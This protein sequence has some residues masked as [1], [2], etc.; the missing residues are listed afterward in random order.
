MERSIA[1]SIG[2]EGMSVGTEVGG[3]SLGE[4]ARSTGRG[5]SM[6]ESAPGAAVQFLAILPRVEE[7]C[8]Y[9]GRSSSIAISSQGMVMVS[10]VRERNRIFELAGWFD[11]GK[12]CE[13]LVKSRNEVLEL[14]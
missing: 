2:E 5:V 1:A 8:R 7:Q 13:V 6:N 3:F 9:R 10:C 11:S 4:Q 12:F 14:S